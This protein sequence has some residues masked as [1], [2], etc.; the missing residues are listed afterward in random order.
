MADNVDR[1]A[2]GVEGGG[3][4]LGKNINAAKMTPTR[5]NSRN[6]RYN[7]NGVDNVTGLPFGLRSELSL[8]TAY[9]AYSHALS[10][11]AH[12]AVDRRRLVDVPHAIV[13][14]VRDGGAR[15]LQDSSREIGVVVLAVRDAVQGGVAP[16]GVHGVGCRRVV[17]V[18]RA[19]QPVLDG[20]GVARADGDA[21]T[22]AV[23]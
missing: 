4:L 15:G 7:K 8:L 13:Q 10:T 14:P 20:R 9:N 12:P 22:P 21:L 2:E 16:R 18:G 11:L 6:A 19:A 1:V 3:L 23:A 17:M 5:N